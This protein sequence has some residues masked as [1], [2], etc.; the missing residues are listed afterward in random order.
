MIA[1]RPLPGLGSG[2]NMPAT[3]MII[4]KINMHPASIQLSS[5]AIQGQTLQTQAQ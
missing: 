2:K 1:N 5:G 3:N 4:D